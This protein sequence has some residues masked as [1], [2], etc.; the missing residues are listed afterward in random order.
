M[1]LERDRRISDRRILSALQGRRLRRSAFLPFH[2]MYRLVA[3]SPSP[4]QSPQRRMCMDTNSTSITILHSSSSSA[5]RR[6]LSSALAP[7]RYLIPV[8]FSPL[9][10]P[11]RHS[12]MK[13]ASGCNPGRADLAT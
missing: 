4:Y 5:L 10:L 7:I 3:P 1:L 2:R 8:Y 13:P 11:E 12:P 9:L 6:G